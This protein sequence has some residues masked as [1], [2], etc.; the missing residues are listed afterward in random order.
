MI[1]DFIEIG[2]FSCEMM[3]YQQ[4]ISL[5]EIQLS[6][7]KETPAYIERHFQDHVARYQSY[8]IPTSCYF[9]AMPLNFHCFRL[10]FTIID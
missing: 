9:E 4:D 6:K 10:G 7:M 5:L 3:T 1:L 2:Y 8:V